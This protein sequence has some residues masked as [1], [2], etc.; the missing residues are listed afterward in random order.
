[1]RANKLGQNASDILRKEAR[2]PQAEARHGKARDHSLTRTG[3]AAAAR[4]RPGNTRQEFTRA[5]LPHS[6]PE[7]TGDGH[8][9]FQTG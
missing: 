8:F 2:S 5:R 7:K 9:T 1:M 6:R 4:T 3:L